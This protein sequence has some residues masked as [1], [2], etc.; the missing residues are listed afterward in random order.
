MFNV[1]KILYLVLFYLIYSLTD[2]A[3]MV[4]AIVQT[5]LNLFSGGPSKSLQDAGKSLGLYVKQLSE[6]LS[7]A[8]EHK[9]F[10]FSDWPEPEVEAKVDEGDL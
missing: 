7:Y 1:L 10:P 8:S 2:I 6:Y 9:P 4:I 5:L 3:L